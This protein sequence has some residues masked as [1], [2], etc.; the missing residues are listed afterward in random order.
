M[1]SI[2]TTMHKPSIFQIVKRPLGESQARKSG[3]T[4][5]QKSQHIARKVDL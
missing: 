5:V 3:A 2:I 1:A 4:D